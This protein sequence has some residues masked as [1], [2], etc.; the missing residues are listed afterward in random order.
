M[1]DDPS[2]P[3][4]FKDHFGHS[5]THFERISTHFLMHCALRGN[6]SFL[7]TTHLIFFAAF[8]FT[9]RFTFLHLRL[10]EPDL[11][12]PSPLF[13]DAVNKVISSAVITP[14]VVINVLYSDSNVR[15]LSE[16]RGS[17]M[18][19]GYHHQLGVILQL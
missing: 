5:K 8:S 12:K 4:S 2:Q 15:R 11:W 10:N 16:C 18:A 3:F 9:M 1:L 14:L 7:N 19:N 13:T 6:P 17:T